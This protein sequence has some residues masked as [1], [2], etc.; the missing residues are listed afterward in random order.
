[1]DLSLSIS[2]RILPRAFYTHNP[3]WVAK[4]LL[5]KILIH[6]TPEGIV[7]GRIV[8][9]EAYY[10]EGDPASHAHK[11]KTKRTKIMWGK[12]GIA[13]VYFTYGMHYL[14]NVIADKEGKAG[15]VLIRAVEP[16]EGIKLMKKR[17]KVDKIKDLTSGPAKL[18]QAFGITGKDNGVDLT[19]GF[20]TIT[21]EEKE[22][23]DKIISTGRIGIK[24]GQEIKLRF[25][26]ANN[27]FVSKR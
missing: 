20:L 19:S 17:R 18:T 1:M 15:A 5:G 2:K 3:K 4:N 21:E 26:L 7:K 27:K 25:Y 6:K 11:G 23:K 16:L 14:F 13:Y 12:P 10:G 24:N 9:T 8:E 22:E